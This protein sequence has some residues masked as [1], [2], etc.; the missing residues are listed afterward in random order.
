[1]AAAASALFT[2]ASPP[3]WTCATTNQFGSHLACR[4]SSATQIIYQHNTHYVRHSPTHPAA[5]P[6]PTRLA[7]V[8]LVSASQYA[9]RYAACAITNRPTDSLCLQMITPLHTPCI[10]HLNTLI[11]PLNAPLLI[12]VFRIFI[13]AAAFPH[14]NYS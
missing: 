3:P 6:V 13:F 4:Q 10:P 1:M 11:T 9:H 8:S 5:G 2:N 12:C 14:G 7:V